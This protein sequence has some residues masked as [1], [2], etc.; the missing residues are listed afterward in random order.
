MTDITAGPNA[1]PRPSWRSP[2]RRFGEMSKVY[3]RTAR[4]TLVAALIIKL[5]I[6]F[7]NASTYDMSNQYD[8]GRHM[9]RTATCG[10]VTE[11]QFYNPPLYYMLGCPAM[12]AGVAANVDLQEDVVKPMADGASFIDIAKSIRKKG[13]EEIV[14]DSGGLFLRYMNSAMLGAVYIIWIFILFPRYLGTGA[15]AFSASLFLLALPGFQKAAV[16]VSGENLLI[17]LTTYGFYLY[18]RVIDRAEITMKDFVVMGLVAGALGL[19][20]P[21]ALVPMGVI[22][23]GMLY[24]LWRA[25]GYSFD[26]KRLLPIVRAGLVYGLIALTISGS[27][28]A[29]RA[30][31]MQGNPMQRYTADSTSIFA[32]QNKAHVVGKFGYPLFYST[33]HFEELW[34]VPNR[35]LDDVA[36]PPDPA[37]HEW[38]QTLNHSFFTLTFS[39]FWGDHW[40]YF[41]GPVVDMEVGE[42]RDRVE[43]SVV[44]K[45]VMFSY[46]FMLTPYLLIMLLVGTVR[47]APQALQ[48]VRPEDI[49]GLLT[50]GIL[51]VALYVYW[52]ATE[53][54]EPYKNSSVKFIYWAHAVPFLI[55][56]IF[57]SGAERFV[58][59]R[60]IQF[61]VGVLFIVGLPLSLWRW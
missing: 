5:L 54:M 48:A 20:R 25:R 4:M 46:A 52:Q 43:A 1:S 61:L 9:F 18:L 33:F 6:T 58:P 22:G 24:H 57:A 12:V 16:M 35:H 45:R 47:L 2:V 38:Q 40:L 27:W 42:Y 26:I 3:P 49:A 7:W 32:P 15:M 13:G 55:V 39:D 23:A 59:A 19:T 53:G 17:F 41:T 34:Q 31:V 10:V 51:S 28:W 56:P 36:D 44:P 29:Y 8:A 60:L 37:L 50:I 30:V 14:N 11:I 21:F